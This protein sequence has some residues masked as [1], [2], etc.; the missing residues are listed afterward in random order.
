MIKSLIRGSP[1]SLCSSVI[2]MYRFEFVKSLSSL[3]CVLCSRAHCESE[4]IF[5]TAQA[6]VMMGL[7]IVLYK[8]SLFSVVSK[9]LR[10]QSG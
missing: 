5:Q 6:Y 4:M 7:K 1:V 3:F 9:L 2:V 8:V 10:L